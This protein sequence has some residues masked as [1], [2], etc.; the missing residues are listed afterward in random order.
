MKK[1]IYLILT[2]FYSSI[3]FTQEYDLE[4]KILD[5]S[6][7]SALAFANIILDG[8]ALGAASDSEWRFV[9]EKI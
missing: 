5:K 6:N 8:S 3:V 7:E 1:Y 2:C 4:G 9:I